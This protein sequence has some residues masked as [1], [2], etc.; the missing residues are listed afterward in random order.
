MIF[1][2]VGPMIFYDI[3]CTKLLQHTIDTSSEKP[4]LQRPRR[5]PIHVQAEVQMMIEDMVKCGII[6]PSRS[7]WCALIVVVTKKNGTKRLCVDF[8]K[9]NNITVRDSYPFSRI[10]DVLNV[11]AGCLYFSALDMKSGYHQVEVAPAD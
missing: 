1:F 9:L 7:P 10:E 2:L 11:L 6:Q 8:K 4:I 5:L 3:G